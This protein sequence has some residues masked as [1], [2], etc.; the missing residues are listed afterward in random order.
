MQ[1]LHY[2][3][4]LDAYAQAYAVGHDPAIL[5]NR[6]RAEQGLGDYPAALDAIEQFVREAP[7]ALKQRV[8]K[9]AD[10]VA[11][12]R[13]HVALVVV[14]CPIAG[15]SVIIDGRIVGTTPLS[16]PIHVAAGRVALSV[17]AK[18]YT[19]FHKEITAS[20]G[21]LTSLDVAPEAE[22]HTTMP[23]ER[24]E[25]YV[26]TGWR[27]AAYAMG[28]A[29]LASLATGGVFGGLVAARTG[30]ASSHC[31]SKACDQAGWAEI[32]DAKTFATVSTIT[33]IA[34]GVLVAGLAAL[35]LFAP[36]R[37]RRVRDRSIH[38]P[39]VRR[40]QW[41]AV[42]GRARFVVVGAA[43]ALV[44]GC[45]DIL[46]WATTPS[47]TARSSMT[48]GV[49]CRSPSMPRVRASLHCQAAGRSSRTTKHFDRVA[50][51]TTE[52]RST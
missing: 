52:R 1:S 16:A 31:P 20:G 50:R 3:E 4:A 9:L 48:P 30:D 26:P 7:D 12:I 6:A 37:E 2:R 19:P 36:H 38:R 22:P 35:F 21:K 41:R 13:S 27:I 45:A 49:N 32:N 14:T 47:K 34:G 33:F 44:V 51:R 11:D 40:N 10:L 5:Y 8:P 42:N 28:G 18:G 39:R 23:S 46:D 29:G 17:E 25:T 24:V 15:A 43:V